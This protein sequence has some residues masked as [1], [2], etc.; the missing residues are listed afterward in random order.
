MTGLVNG[1]WVR[2]V[3]PVHNGVDGFLKGGVFRGVTVDGAVVVQ[4]TGTDRRSYIVRRDEV[5]ASRGEGK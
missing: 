3:K 4:M 5:E 1:Q 2:F